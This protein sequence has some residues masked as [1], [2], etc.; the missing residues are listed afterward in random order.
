MRAYVSVVTPDK[1]IAELQ[2]IL[3]FYFVKFDRQN[4]FHHCLRI[5]GPAISDCLDGLVSFFQYKLFDWQE[6]VVVYL[7]LNQNFV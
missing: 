1:C 2:T 3:L 5:G 7:H 6:F 4:F